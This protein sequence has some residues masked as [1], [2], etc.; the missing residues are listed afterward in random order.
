MTVRIVK[1]RYNVTVQFQFGNIRNNGGSHGCTKDVQVL[2]YTKMLSLCMALERQE[3]LTYGLNTMPTEINTL[4]R[5]TGQKN[6]LE[7]TG[8]QLY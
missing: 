8:T 4:E 7:R 2:L 6:I 1:T 5:Q 3:D